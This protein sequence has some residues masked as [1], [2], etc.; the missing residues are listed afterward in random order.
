MPV[1][2]RAFA[3]LL[4]DLFDTDLADIEVSAA[5]LRVQ[6]SPAIFVGAHQAFLAWLA[7][8]IPL[9]VFMAFEVPSM[10]TLPPAP[11]PGLPSGTK[12]AS[13]GSLEWLTS[14][15][16]SAAL[17]VAKPPAGAVWLTGVP[18]RWRATDES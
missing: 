1:I 16:T 15:V 9:S 10:L 5:Q 7:W 6:R 8:A 3:A 18:T 14:S 2:G 11:V 17:R 4:A 12:G 13:S